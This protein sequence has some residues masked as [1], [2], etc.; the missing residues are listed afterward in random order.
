MKG[1]EYVACYNKLSHRLSSIDNEII[2]K[3]IIVVTRR[4]YRNHPRI[5]GNGNWPN[6][7]PPFPSFFEG[8]YGSLE[9]NKWLSGGDNITRHASNSPA[10]GFTAVDFPLPHPDIQRSFFRLPSWIRRRRC[11]I[12]QRFHTA[13]TAAPIT[14]TQSVRLSTFF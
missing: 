4:G 10:K 11:P 12:Y 9:V 8:S 13:A 7:V 6:F 14:S 1:G 3:R 5:C 2:K